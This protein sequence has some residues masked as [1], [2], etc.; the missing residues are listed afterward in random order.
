MTIVEKFDNV[1]ALISTID[2]YGMYNDSTCTLNVRY[3]QTSSSNPGDVLF[4][5][6][7]PAF[8]DGYVAY[9]QVGQQ[10]SLS[11]SRTGLIG[12]NR[13]KNKIQAIAITGTPDTSDIGI[14]L[15]WPS[16][17]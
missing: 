13:V 1:N 14:T 10:G 12:I 11:E 17:A 16:K 6:E 9:Q 4:E 3:T 15:T 8:R 2:G 5:M 7:L